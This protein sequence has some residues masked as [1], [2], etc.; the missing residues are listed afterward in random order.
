[1]PQKLPEKVGGEA[2]H[3]FRWV[4]GRGRAVWIPKIKD[5]RVRWGEF[6]ISQITVSAGLCF[7]VT[8]PAAPGP[9]T[10]ELGTEAAGRVQKVTPVAEWPLVKET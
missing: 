6:L 7:I 9:G 1:M 2:A 5:F 3:L 4:V 10:P 8:G